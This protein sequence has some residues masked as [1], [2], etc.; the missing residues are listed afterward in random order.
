M[1]NKEFVLLLFIIFIGCYFRF[2]NLDINPP[3]VFRDE[4]EKG[5]TA[6]SILNTGGCVSILP[7]QYET[8]YRFH[9]FPLF[10]NVMGVY[11]SALYQYI[12]IPFIYL[13][14]LNETSV[15][16]PAALCGVITILLTYF[17]CTRFI[18]EKTALIGTLFLAVSP[19]HII[20]SRWAQQ[21][22]FIPLFIVL[23]IYL[24]LDGI[25][26]KRKINLLLSAIPFAL[27]IYT[28]DIGKVYIPILLVGMFF[29]YRSEI[30]KN[31]V[32]FLYFLILLILLNL[33]TIHFLL[34]NPAQSTARFSKISILSDE[35]SGISKILLTFMKNYYL[36]YSPSFLFINGDAE[37]RHSVKSV[38]M[39]HY[40]EAPLLLLGLIKLF[41]F[42]DKFSKLLLYWFLTFPIPASLTRE[43]IPHGLRAITG[44]PM[45]HI[46][47][48]I[49]GVYLYTIINAI[50]SGEFTL[51][52]RRIPQRLIPTPQFI[53]TIFLLSL[54]LCVTL[55]SID[56]F[57]FYPSYSAFNWQYGI[58]QSIEFCTPYINKGY[59]VFVSG[60]ITQAPYLY[61]FYTK[62]L[63]IRY[64]E[65]NFNYFPYIFLP[66]GYDINKISSNF[67][68][69]KYF[70]VAFPGEITDKKPMKIIYAPQNFIN[71]LTYPCLEIYK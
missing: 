39:M 43:G 71:N 55:F 52:Q 7:T 33:P 66:F 60:Y 57:V 13:M 15:R 4:A 8:T 16:A 44:L 47:S 41:R 61:L 49:G 50:H 28:Y 37:L 14:G 20:F 9:R 62:Y 42:R 34:Y 3:S 30:V 11:T 70:I 27:G 29:I 67:V 48:G 53:R 18:S 59:K 23:G 54:V 69:K 1:K 64:K 17:L 35:N 58:K 40:Y 36:H 24:F 5:Y 10:I 21:G 38:G 6:Y 31:K 56:L 19:W 65:N 2:F 32:Y 26:G 51:Q 25:I 63:P 12:D 45:L 68:F 46:I 22:I